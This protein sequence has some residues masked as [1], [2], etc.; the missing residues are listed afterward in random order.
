MRKIGFACAALFAADPAHGA[1]PAPHISE[2]GAGR[3]ALI[4]TACIQ[5]KPA[6]RHVSVTSST[7]FCCGPNGACATPLASTILELPPM[8][9]RT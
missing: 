7:R 1:P 4:G 5:A 9:G 8:Q 6:L 2:T 3:P